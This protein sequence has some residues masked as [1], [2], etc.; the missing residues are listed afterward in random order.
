M[1]ASCLSAYYL[2]FIS[3]IGPSQLE[4]ENFNDNVY[5]LYLSMLASSFNKQK[6]FQLFYAFNLVLKLF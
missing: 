4:M 6:K 3:L 2:W 1:W 5:S